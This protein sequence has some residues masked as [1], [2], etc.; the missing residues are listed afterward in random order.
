MNPNEP[1]LY[2]VLGELS[3]LHGRKDA[4]AEYFRKALRIDPNFEEARA[5]LKSL[6]K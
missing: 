6:E 3:I 1:G 2:T 5:R 4:A